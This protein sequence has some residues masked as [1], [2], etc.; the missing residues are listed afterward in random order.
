[1]ANNETKVSQLP[2]SSNVAVSDRFLI[3]KNPS[4]N[5]SVRTVNA[6]IVYANITLSSSVPATPTSNGIAGTIRYDSSYV[7]VCIANNTWKRATLNS[8]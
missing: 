1:M 8:W 4:G 5:A 3:L 2:T 6:D 7:Y